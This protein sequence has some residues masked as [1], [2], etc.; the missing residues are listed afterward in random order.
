VTDPDENEIM[1]NIRKMYQGKLSSYRPKVDPFDND[2]TRAKI[3]ALQDVTI[4][5][6]TL[7][8]KPE[9]VHVHDINACRFVDDYCPNRDRGGNLTIRTTAD[10]QFWQL[11]ERITYHEKTLPTLHAIIVN[12]RACATATAGQIHDLVEQIQRLINHCPLPSP[13]TRWQA[14]KSAVKHPGPTPEAVRDENA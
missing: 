8:Y 1:E 3:A 4:P 6:G 12:H 2:E 14:L 13:Q 5:A 7:E 10:L 9:H 11:A